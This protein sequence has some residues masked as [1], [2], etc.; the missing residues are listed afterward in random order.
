MRL[1]GT[2]LLAGA[3]GLSGAGRAAADV[4]VWT[5]L[6]DNARTG[7]NL[8]E[9]M[10]TPSQV[11][12]GGF[13]LRFFHN[14][15]GYVYAQ[16]LYVSHVS[17]AGKGVHNVVYVATEHDSVYAFDADSNL[18][19]DAAPLWQVS[20]LGAGETSVPYPDTL[21][22]DIVTE[23]GITGTPVIDLASQT[24]YVVAKSRLRSGGNSTYFQR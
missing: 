1:I 7:Q 11:A 24:L 12:S 6:Y 2:T 16:P 9:T 23:V 19:T 20:L 4:N 13:G 8:A 14:V 10:L 3:L 18:G 21:T 15:D 5:Y 17:I 22:D